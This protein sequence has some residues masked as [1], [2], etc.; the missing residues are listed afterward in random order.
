MLINQEYVLSQVFTKQVALHILKSEGIFNNT[1]HTV[2]VR[3]YICRYARYT[4][5]HDKHVY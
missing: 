3:T 1:T 4:V 5:L 2:Y